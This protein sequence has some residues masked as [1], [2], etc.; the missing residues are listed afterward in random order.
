MHNWDDLSYVLFE[1]WGVVSL[2]NEAGKS[3][4]EDVEVVRLVVSELD[5]AVVDKKLNALVELD[6]EVAKSVEGHQ[7]KV[8]FWEKGTGVEPLKFECLVVLELNGSLV[9][10]EINESVRRRVGYLVVLDHWENLCDLGGRETERGG[11]G[12]DDR[13][14]EGLSLFEEV[15]GIDRLVELEEVEK[16]VIDYLEEPLFVVLGMIVTPAVWEKQVLEIEEKFGRC[17]LKVS[18]FFLLTFFSSSS[19]L[20]RLD[21]LCCHNLFLLH[22]IF[23]VNL[24]RKLLAHKHRDPFQTALLVGEPEVWETHSEEEKGHFGSWSIFNKTCWVFVHFEREEEKLATVCEEQFLRSS[25]KID[26]KRST[27]FS[28]LRL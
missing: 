20:K 25:A 8:H 24:R 6:L 4:K 23:T 3:K 10:N 9:F 26:G 16:G 5:H 27:Y 2:H 13:T 18:L 28:S 1:N 15:E 22:I 21:H 14:E 12:V 7:G 19:Q 17:Y 11:K